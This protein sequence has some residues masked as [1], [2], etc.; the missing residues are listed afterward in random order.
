M[1]ELY[2]RPTLSKDDYESRPNKLNVHNVYTLL[3]GEKEPGV[4]GLGG[5]ES[6][7]EL[8]YGPASLY[9]SQ[10]LSLKF[11]SR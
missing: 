1:N 11:I 3:K 9:M 6:W 10:F 5:D 2:P 4:C 7:K 8:D